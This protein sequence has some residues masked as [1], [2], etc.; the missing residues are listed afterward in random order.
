MDPWSLMALMFSFISLL[1]C[2]FV[3]H[4]FTEIY[5]KQIDIT[6]KILKHLRIHDSPTI[7]EEF[8]G[9]ITEEE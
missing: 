9:D 7:I 4:Y 3:Y 5:E 2:G 1:V 6:D 8:Q